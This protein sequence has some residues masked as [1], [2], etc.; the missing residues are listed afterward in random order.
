MSNYLLFY[1]LGSCVP[2]LYGLP[3]ELLLLIFLIK[4]KTKKH[5][6]IELADQTIRTQPEISNTGLEYLRMSRIRVDPLDSNFFP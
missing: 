3:F 2:L 5:F 1:F 6:Q 4:Q